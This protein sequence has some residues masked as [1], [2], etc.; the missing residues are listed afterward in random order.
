V[1]VELYLYLTCMPLWHVMG[2]H[3]PVDIGGHEMTKVGR[4]QQK[5]T[6]TVLIWKPEGV[7]PLGRPLIRRLTCRATK[8]N[9]TFSRWSRTGH[10][11]YHRSGYIFISA[12][13]GFMCTAKGL[14][15]PC[16]WNVSTRYHLKEGMK[17]CSV[18]FEDL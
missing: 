2:H 10:R 12:C 17:P 7:R 4:Q 6:F 1:W 16:P 11:F 3:L 8:H 15:L 5:R 9:C 14:G 18:P 13:R